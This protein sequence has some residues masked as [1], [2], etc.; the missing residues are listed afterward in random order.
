M[1]VHVLATGGTIASTDSEGGARPS[2][3]GSALAEAAALDDVA[4]EI[5][6]ETVAERPGFDMDL[7]T[8]ATVLERIDD[9]AGTGDVDG[10]VV[11][12]GTDTME[13]TAYALDL[14]L[15]AGPPVV[16]TGAQRRP[17]EISADGPAN[18]RTAV[19]AA[20]AARLESG[21]VLAFDGQLHA[22]APV[23][24][25]HTQALS[26]FTSPESGPV[27]TFSRGSI[28]WHREPPTSDL[29]V[30]P[31]AL[32]GAHDQD[33]PIVVSGSGVPADRFERA[34]AAADGV[35]LAGTGLGNATAGIADAVAAADLPVVVASRCFAG[36][37]EPV[38]GT[39]GGGVSLAGAGVTFAGALQPWKARVALQLALATDRPPA[40]VLGGA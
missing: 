28:R 29:A 20:T 4:D 5:T 11:T 17:D 7:A 30:G 19:R 38:Y 27:A 2:I 8:C 40:D 18:L 13:E 34:A 31:G 10:V 25:A 3:D 6:V 35:V 16:V 26:T 9:V 22:A 33:V 36:P 1:R 23:T 21:C 24:K 32:R 37:T 14:A 12:H 15:G 39:P